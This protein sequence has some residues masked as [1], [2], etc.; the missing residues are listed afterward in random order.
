MI[1]DPE[2]FKENMRFIKVARSL[3]ENE[4]NKEYLRNAFSE[5]ELNENQKNW[6]THLNT[7]NSRQLTW[8]YD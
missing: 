5:T 6:N 3:I 2:L 4:K 7:Q 8:V 1:E